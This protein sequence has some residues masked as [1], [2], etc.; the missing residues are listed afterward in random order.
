MHCRITSSL[1]QK[2]LAL[3]QI[4]T[5][6]LFASIT[7]HYYQVP[8]LPNYYVL[9]PLLPLLCITY[10]GN[11]E[12]FM[13]WKQLLLETPNIVAFCQHIVLYKICIDEIFRSGLAL[14]LSYVGS[15]K[16]KTQATTKE[17][18]WKGGPSA[19]NAAD[20][21]QFDG[22]SITVTVVYSP[23]SADFAFKVYRKPGTA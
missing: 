16:Y 18:E 5:L 21:A 1:L 4:T 14:P 3:L 2:P 15:M 20:P 8:L 6:I 17:I 10:W 23:A 7:S 11:L 22:I 9:L 19:K 12:I 13:I